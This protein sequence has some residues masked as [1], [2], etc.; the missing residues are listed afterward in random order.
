MARL[1]KFIGLSTRE[2]VLTIEA[3]VFLLA[4]KMLLLFVPF[5]YCL[6]ILRNK[7]KV[8]HANI[9]IE[10]LANIKCAI[11]RTQWL[12]IW[13]NK[14][15]VMCIASRWMLQRRNIP[16]SISLGVTFDENKKMMA[17]A[18]LKAGNFDLVENDGNFR[19]IFYF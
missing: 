1:K 4:A 3:A 5:K 7:Q 15:I 12:M 10:Q 2:K 14:C 17:H 6:K 9:E 19:E 8:E 13:R 11:R 16:S 18:W